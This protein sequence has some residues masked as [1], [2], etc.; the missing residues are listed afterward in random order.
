MAT[1]DAVWQAMK[2]SHVWHMVSAMASHIKA[3]HIEP[4]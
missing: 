3:R 4:I 1:Q 2:L